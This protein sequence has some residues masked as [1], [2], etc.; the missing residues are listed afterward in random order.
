[1]WHLKLPLMKN[2]KSMLILKFGSIWSTKETLLDQDLEETVITQRGRGTAFVNQNPFF[3]FKVA[4]LLLGT[5]ETGSQHPFQ[6]D[7]RQWNVNRGNM[8]PFWPSSFSVAPPHILLFCKTDTEKLRSLWEQWN[9]IME[10]GCHISPRK[11]TPCSPGGSASDNWART[12]VLLCSSHCT[13]WDD[14]LHNLA[15]LG[16]FD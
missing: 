11:T 6:L 13:I 14:L 10:R 3:L 1:M 9:C 15:S 7:S 4:G 16:W 12:K 5:P 2:S 8:G